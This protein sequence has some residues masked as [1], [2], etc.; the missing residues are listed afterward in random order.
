MPWKEKLNCRKVKCFAVSCAKY[1]WIFRTKCASFFILLFLEWKQFE[2]PSHPIFRMFLVKLFSLFSLLSV[3]NHCSIHLKVL[4][5][6]KIYF[7]GRWWRWRIITKYCWW[8]SLVDD[9][10]V[11]HSQDSSVTSILKSIYDR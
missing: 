3:T 11:I 2:I 6:P 4:V 10:D 9:Q 7:Y 5:V 1:H 8:W